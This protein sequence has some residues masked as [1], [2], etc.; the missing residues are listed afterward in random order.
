[1]RKILALPPICLWPLFT[2]AQEPNLI[3]TDRPSIRT[4]RTAEPIRIDGVLDEAAWGTA[5]IGSN[6]IQREPFVGQPESERTEFRVLYDDENLYFGITLYDREPGKILARAKA[7][8]SSQIWKDDLVSVN[9][10]PQH[11]YR[12]VYGFTV[13]PLGAMLDGKGVNNGEQFITT[14][15]TVWEAKTRVNSDGWVA[16]IRIPFASLEYDPARNS[17]MG[18]DVVRGLPRCSE[19]SDWA[20]LVPPF[21]SFHATQYGCLEGIEIPTR[22]WRNLSLLPYLS[23][24]F[25]E[26]RIAGNREFV[27]KPG[28]DFK[29]PLRRNAIAQITVKTDFSQV[30]I[31]DQQV[32]LNRFE[33]FFPEKRPF[34]LEGLHSFEFGISEFAQLFYSRRIGLE[35]GN[36]V[37]VVAGVRS[38]GKIG[39]ADYGVLNIQTENTSAVPDRNFSVLRVRQDIGSRSDIGTMIVHRQDTSGPDGGNT[40]GGVDGTFRSE[41]GRVTVTSFASGTHSNPNSAGEMEGNGGAAYLRTVWTPGLWEIRQSNIYV[42]DRFNPAVGY[43]ERTGIFR[44]TLSVD[45][46]ILLPERGIKRLTLETA[47][48]V[49]SSDEFNALRDWTAIVDGL[50]ETVSGYTFLAAGYLM[51]QDVLT[52]FDLKPGVTI[53][54][55]RYT[56][57]Q[58]FTQVT[59]PYQNPITLDLTY[60]YA[61]F[62]GGTI[63][64]W[65][66]TIYG[67]PFPGLIFKTGAQIN[68]IRLPDLSADYVSNT[69]NFSGS[70]SFRPGLAL[71]TNSGWNRTDD[72]LEL[73]Y[74]FRWRFAPLSEFFAVY[75]EERT[76]SNFST[77]LRGLIFKVVVHAWL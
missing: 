59:T 49:F 54:V 40:A 67:K 72:I 55:G 14:W 66:P 76:A 20:P 32:N 48:N 37:P 19:L 58:L 2:L 21:Q 16:E 68:W 45:R 4:I 1:M 23:T 46:A 57:P 43:F 52:S 13:T 10:D 41:D 34:F 11:D 44:G 42:S 65:S 30:D 15:D 5:P 29:Y 63:H 31:D 75:S 22:G 64:Q 18:L 60:K 8:D 61:G 3:P 77:H 28:I 24:G 25:R 38:Y 70:Y 33:L 69:L 56:H 12:S 35:G 27:F 74:R 17:T 50:V 53:P 6:F 47:G 51:S 62:F 26:D 73:Q 36:E 9:L 71:E 39:G 7:P